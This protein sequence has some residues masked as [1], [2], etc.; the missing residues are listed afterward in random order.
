MK[1]QVA[2]SSL[3][4]SVLGASFCFAVQ[5]IRQD[6]EAVESSEQQEDD[7][8][9]S[10][11]GCSREQLETRFAT[12]QSRAVSAVL[13]QVKHQLDLDDQWRVKVEEDLTEA[14]SATVKEMVEQAVVNRSE[15][16]K[17]GYG[18]DASILRDNLKNLMWA[19]VEDSLPRENDAAFAELKEMYEQSLKLKTHNAVLGIVVFL[20]NQLCLSEEQTRALTAQFESNWDTVFNNSTGMLEIH[21]LSRQDVLELVSEEDI[22]KILKPIQFEKFKD[23]DRVV[24][25]YAISRMRQTEDDLD[26]LKSMCNAVIDMKIAEYKELVGLNESQSRVFSVARKRTIKNVLASLTE[27]TN[28]ERIQNRV[29]NQSFFSEPAISRCINEDVWQ[30]ALRKVFDEEQL[31][32]IQKREAVRREMAQE[33]AAN[34]LVPRAIE[35]LNLKQQKKIVELVKSQMGDAETNY[36]AALDG[37]TKVADED[38]QDVLTKEQWRVFKPILVARRSGARRVPGD[39]VDR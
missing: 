13:R 29:S 4:L 12:Y 20:D 21:G 22:R 32:I 19:E 2:L 14:V 28:E 23:L 7:Q 37:L 17:I 31:Q 25:F 15:H 36:Y 6:V 24:S 18:F 26:D 33:R 38:Y 27:N 5:D 10:L 1:A 8:I 11:F 9:A 3:V 30:A 16:S 34:F 35:G 39:A